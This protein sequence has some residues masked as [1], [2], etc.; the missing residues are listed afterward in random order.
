MPNPFS[1][2]SQVPWPVYLYMGTVDSPRTAH[3]FGSVRVTR[4]A[5]ICWAWTGDKS[6]QKQP[7]WPRCPTQGLR[8]TRDDG[9]SGEMREAMERNHEALPRPVNLADLAGESTSPP[10]ASLGSWSGELVNQD[11]I[12]RGSLLGSPDG[13]LDA[14]LDRLS[15]LR[16]M[17]CLS[18]H[19]GSQMKSCVG[20]VMPDGSAMTVV[21]FPIRGVRKGPTVAFRALATESASRVPALAFRSQRP[22]LPQ[23]TNK[24]WKVFSALPGILPS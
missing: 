11:H 3:L 9:T 20:V 6:V 23:F 21:M 14:S 22:W 1:P 19:C 18:M 24:T 5:A 13:K 10:P 17:G 15:L 16:I 2:P 4:S 8:I 7:V 12:G